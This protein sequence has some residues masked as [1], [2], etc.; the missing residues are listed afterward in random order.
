MLHVDTWQETMRAEYARY[1]PRAAEFYSLFPKALVRRMRAEYEAADYIVVPGSAARQ[2]FVEQGV[3]AERVVEI[4]FGIDTGYF[5]AESKP[6]SSTFQ[7]TYLSRLELLKGVHYLLEAW[8]G[9]GLQEARL[10]LAG[11]V[12]PEVQEIL[13]KHARDESIQ[14]LGELPHERARQLLVA[15]DVVVFP[16]ICDSFGLVVLEA[17]SSGRTV[18]A[19]SRSAGPDVIDDGVDGFVVPAHDAKALGER[20]DW[21]YRHRDECAEMGRRARLKVTSHYDVRS[22]GDR[23]VRAYTRMLR[24]ERPISESLLRSRRAS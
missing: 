8:A 14:V 13:A 3:P 12:L 2:S 21:L 22:Y 23:L 17:M 15:S 7:V 6:P 24:R 5:A 20:L 16:S 1:A 9:L 10:S 4:P 11:A 18:I 19:T